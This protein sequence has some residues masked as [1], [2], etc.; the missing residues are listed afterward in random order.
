MVKL[1]Q[2]QK[3]QVEEA[4]PPSVA[5]IVEQ[6]RDREML[7]ATTCGAVFGGILAMGPGAVLGSGVGLIGGAIVGQIRGML[8][9]REL[10]LTEIA[11]DSFENQAPIAV[12][13]PQTTG[14]G[15]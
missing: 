8:A 6:T 15:R 1:T 14:Q 5:E 3:Q 10:T 2:E 12:Q 13:G 7:R 11:A 9:A 4:C